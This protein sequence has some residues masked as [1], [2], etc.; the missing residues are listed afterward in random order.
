MPSGKK[1]EVGFFLT[2]RW[3][4]PLNFQNNYLVNLA[5]NAWVLDILGDQGMSARGVMCGRL[6]MISV[7]PK[8]R[9]KAMWQ[10]S[11]K[12]AKL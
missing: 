9:L 2:K 10:P 12:I 8:R 1:G 5:V 7:I 6:A 11:E 4:A 3:W